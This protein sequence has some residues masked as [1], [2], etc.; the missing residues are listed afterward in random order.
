VAGI[1]DSKSRVMD[2]L[3]T[4]EGRRQIASGELQIKYA[5]FN[6]RQV[7]YA[8]GTDGYLEDPGRTFYFEAHSDNND[9]IILETDADGD[10]MPFQSDTYNSYNGEFFA[11]G[12]TFQTGSINLISDEVTGNAV[13]SF[14]RQMIIGSRNIFRSEKGL[15]FKPS[16][17]DTSNIF[18]LAPGVSRSINVVGINNLSAVFEDPLFATTLN[19]G[20]LPPKFQ[21]K[22]GTQMPW[23]SYTKLGGDDESDIYDSFVGGLTEGGQIKQPL[24]IEMKYPTNS[25]LE[26]NILGQVFAQKDNK[27][28]KLALINAGNLRYSRETNLPNPQVYYAGNLYRNN[29]GSLCFARVFTLIFR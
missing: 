12:S 25:S 11:S 20:Y 29:Y 10:L 28:Y 1:L 17:D 9:S 14:T 13:D 19:Y 24:I 3:I 23:G 5:T 18:T 26:N 21:N 22:Q 7:V 8:S 4:S 27:V 2:T 6:D 15:N 16:Y